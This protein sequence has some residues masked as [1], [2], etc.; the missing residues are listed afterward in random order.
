MNVRSEMKEP[1]VF[2]RELNYGRSIYIYFCPCHQASAVMR[3]H[4]S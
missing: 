1:V 2:V 4:A 3:V